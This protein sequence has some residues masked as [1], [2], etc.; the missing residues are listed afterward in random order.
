MTTFECVFCER[1]FNSF[2]YLAVHLQGSHPNVPKADIER[3]GYI[4]CS[5]GFI[6]LNE[7]GLRVHRH[8]HP[9][10]ASEK[11]NLKRKRKRSDSSVSESEPMG[12]GKEKRGDNHCKRPANE[13][14]KNK[15]EYRKKSKKTYE[16]NEE[17]E[18][19]RIL[20]DQGMKINYM[21]SD[22]N[23]L[24]R[25]IAD[26]IGG[27]Q[28]VHSNFR[29]KIMAYIEDNKDH[30]K[31]F[32]DVDERMNDYLDRM[33]YG[34][35]WGGHLELFAASQCLG[36]DIH[37]H[38]V[39]APRYVLQGA[40]G[41]KDDSA[42]VGTR[43]SSRNNYSVNNG[44]YKKEIHLSYHGD[45]HYNSVRS[46]N[47]LQ[48]NVAVD[49]MEMLTLDENNDRKSVV[50]AHSGSSNSPKNGEEQVINDEDRE[51]GNNETTTAEITISADPAIDPAA[52]VAE[53]VADN[54]V[55]EANENG[56]RRY[57]KKKKSKMVNQDGEKISKKEFRMHTR[58]KLRKKEEKEAI[59]E[60][61]VNREDNIVYL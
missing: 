49:T 9:A 51:R 20:A 17:K 10:H 56:T 48:S 32:L 59:P 53:A 29:R 15:K 5:C 45:C 40:G 47:E 36:I 57:E 38:Q 21:E 37:V 39:D 28:S 34:G 30:F 46:L 52:T 16:S 25:A 3:N 26:Q 24:F 7:S 44:S 6:C 19:C 61:N 58:G 8:R 13:K 43:K 60:I 2:R 31:L 35:E 54:T 41:K 42:D 18:F 50:D 23:C 27:D 11:E 55:N 22:G 33:K 4:R 12:K 1:N 14:Q